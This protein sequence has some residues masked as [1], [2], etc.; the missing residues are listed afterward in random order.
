MRR[1]VAGLPFLLA[2]LKIS[3]IRLR[4]KWAGLTLLLIATGI[5]MLNF[6]KGTLNIVYPGGWLLA[7]VLSVLWVR[8]QRAYLD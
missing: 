1:L 4:F 6:H 2:L 8:S 3:W 7:L 5:F